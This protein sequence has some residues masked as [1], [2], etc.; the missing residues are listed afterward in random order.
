MSNS[1]RRRHRRRFYKHS[2]FAREAPAPLALI[3]SASQKKTFCTHTQT[4]IWEDVFC[5]N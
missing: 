5:V 1:R 3:S 4:T 2:Q